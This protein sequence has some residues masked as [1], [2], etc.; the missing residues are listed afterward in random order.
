MNYK[1]ISSAKVDVAG[2][3]FRDLA[4]DR[5]FKRAVQSIVGDCWVDGQYISC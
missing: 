1:V 5:D 2:M 4:G 3:G